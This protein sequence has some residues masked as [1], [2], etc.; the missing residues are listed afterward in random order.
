[1]LYFSFK[2]LN[3][4]KISPYLQRMFC[5]CLAG[6]REEAGGVIPAPSDAPG[7]SLSSAGKKK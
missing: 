4:T 6:G 7:V 5:S 3:G 2:V 1:M